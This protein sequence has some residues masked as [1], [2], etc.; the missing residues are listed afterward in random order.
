MKQSNMKDLYVLD[1]TEPMSVY[2][3]R[4]MQFEESLVLKKCICKQESNKSK[5]TIYRN[6]ETN[7]YY[8]ITSE[9]GHNR[10]EKDT[11]TPLEEY[12]KLRYILQNIKELKEIHKVHYKVKNLKKTNKI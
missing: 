7:T 2:G 9:L 6:L 12:Y 1:A 4:T 5:E 8:E 3:S 11:I 10:V